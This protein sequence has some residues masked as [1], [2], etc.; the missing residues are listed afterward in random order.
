QVIRYKSA[1]YSVERPLVLGGSLAGAGPALLACYSTYGLQLG[2]A[3]Q[4][5]DDVL[6]VF[7]DPQDTGKPAGDDLREGKR[8]LLVAYARERASAAQVAVLDALLGDHS[9]GTPGL[10]RVREI[11][12]ATG[13]LKRVD[14]L[15]DALATGAAEELARADI[16]DEARAALGELI[17]AAT[18]RVR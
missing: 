16:T 15:I 7:G 2:E 3:F 5:R 4:L 9:L 8:T 12:I 17:G 18:V 11:I 14:Q 1:K 6:G 13:A 10:D